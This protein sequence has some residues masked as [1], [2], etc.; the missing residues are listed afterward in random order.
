[1]NT[2]IFSFVIPVFSKP[3]DV[4][5]KYLS[6]LFEMSLKDIEVTA[7]FDGANPELEKVAFDLAKVQSIVIEHGG[8]PKARNTGLG[9]AIGKYV[10]FWDADCYI[11][12]DHAKRMLEEFEAVPDADFVYSGYEMAEGQGEFQSEAFDAYSLQSGNYISSMAP[13]R[14]DK[15][16]RWDE[17]L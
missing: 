12:P 8:A 16:F 13:I 7:V 1:M 5:R 9:R 2:P 6:S 15:A 3:P 17:S 14:H 4:F 10:W 11:K